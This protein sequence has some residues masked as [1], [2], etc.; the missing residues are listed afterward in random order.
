MPAAVADT[1]KNRLS[2]ITDGGNTEA[3]AGSSTAERIASRKPATPPK[4]LMR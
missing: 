1:R 3:D 2:K 4:P